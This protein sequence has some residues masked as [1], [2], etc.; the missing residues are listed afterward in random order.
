MPLFLDHVFM[1]YTDGVYN[2]ATRTYDPVDPIILSYTKDSLLFDTKR[3]T[4][5]AQGIEF[6]NSY[7]LPYVNSGI[8]S[9]AG[10][11]ASHSV[12]YY[13]TGIEQNPDGSISY[14]YSYSYI[15]PLNIA[16]GILDN[17]NG[18]AYITGMSVDENGIMSYKYAQIFHSTEPGTFIETELSNNSYVI[19]SLSLSSE[20]IL[21]YSYSQ[22]N[23]NLVAEAEYANFAGEAETLSYLYGVE[24]SPNLSNSYSVIWLYKDEDNE[25]RVTFSY[26]DLTTVSGSNSVTALIIDNTTNQEPI[27]YSS[28]YVQTPSN[29]IGALVNLLDFGYEEANPNN[30]AYYKVLT[31]IRQDGDGKIH[32]EFGYINARLNIDQT[33]ETE[34]SVVTSIAFN[35]NVGKLIV[36]SQTLS[37]TVTDQPAYSLNSDNSSIKFAYNIVQDGNGHISFDQASINIAFDNLSDNMFGVVTDVNIDSFGKISYVHRDLSTLQSENMF[38]NNIALG[39]ES[40]SYFI[41][42]IEQ[43]VYGHIT[44]TYSGISMA[45]SNSSNGIDGVLTNVNINE[46]GTLSY[47]SIDNTVNEGNYEAIDFQVGEKVSKISALSNL[48]ISNISQDKY[49]KISYSYSAIYTVPEEYD[50]HTI[51]LNTHSLVPD[52]AAPTENQIPVLYSLELTNNRINDNVHEFSYKTAYVPTK[53]YVDNL[54]TANDALRYAGTVVPAAE[55]NGECTFSNN[56]YSTG[57]VY[58]VNGSGYFGIEYVTGGDM[59]ISHDDNAVTDD[60]TYWDII[61][62]NLNLVTKYDG[63]FQ[64][65]S[66]VIVAVNLEDDGKLSYLTYYLSVSNNYG[67]ENSIQYL[68]SNSDRTVLPTNAVQQIGGKKVVTGVSIAQYGLSTQ[69]SYEYDYIYVDQLHHSYVIENEGGA[70]KVVGSISLSD[71]GELRYSYVDIADSAYHYLINGTGESIQISNEWFIPEGTYML[72]DIWLENGHVVSYNYSFVTDKNVKFIENTTNNIYIGGTIDSMSESP[73][74]EYFDGISY[75]NNGIFY[76]EFAYIGNDVNVGNKLEVN[77]NAYIN[78]ITYLRGDSYIG[79]EDTDKISLSS[80][81]IDLNANSS[82]SPIDFDNLKALWGVIEV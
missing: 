66:N 35:K 73:D 51:G 45:F 70:S 21:S 1:T 57:A 47:V 59:I 27:I 41:T 58:K 23:I 3:R 81:N 43:D 72:K 17:S 7:V 64:N 4:I 55:I 62:E 76:S 71:S 44:Y 31:D 32:Y 10:V 69:L 77:G 46:N 48:F 5:Y 34:N 33:E 6:G 42:G 75:V 38:I 20:G 13:I 56:D 25:N 28:K 26:K 67:R 80:K 22:L 49:G 9:G 65:E 37:A 82:V 40:N 19:N 12:T 39:N 68:S 16:E 24:L 36:N 14:S 63:E 18:G 60:F 52:I 30:V 54:M 61:N 11:D 74:S 8:I 2:E 79:N 50:F 78:G 53:Q 15:N 29:S